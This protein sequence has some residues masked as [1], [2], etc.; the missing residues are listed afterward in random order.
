MRR[1]TK[2]AAVVLSGSLGMA[3]LAACGS[4]STASSS[5]PSAST[6]SVAGTLKVGMAYDVGGR[7]D[8]SFNDSAGRGLDKAKT[9]FG[10][11]TK[12]LQATPTD[13]DADRAS[14]LDQLA[15]N[16][17]NPIIAI[18]FAYSAALKT[19]AAKYPNIKFAIVDDASNTAANITNLVFTEEQSSYLVGVAAALKSK[20]NTVGFI[21][22]VDVPLIHKFQAGFQAG[23]AS[24]KPSDKVLVKYLTP[25]GNF[26][27]FSSPN[28]G[29]AAAQG[30]LSQ[31]ADVIYSAAGSS[32][33]GAIEAVH[34][35][36]GAW[37]IGVDSDQ[38]NL[39]GLAQ[40]KSSI[41]TS[42]LKN[43]DVAVYDYIQS[44]KSG[45]PLTGTQVF[46][47]DK[48]GVGYSTSGGFVDDIKA[49]LDKATADI[50]SKKVVVPTT[51]K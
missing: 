17:Y 26:A 2:I 36:P 42:A 50:T 21:G 47:L 46:S 3:S 10:I 43:V 32:G 38:Y 28:L 8:F 6:A 31:G 41:L 35:Q 33:N 23:V 19:E 16:G 37:A 30:M 1:V 11:Q 13:S 15:Q 25:A 45:T 29:K 5:S 48:N 34:A 14:R 20:T 18:G 4:N 51:V 40:Y 22:G 12:E 44:V 24:V 7:G 9:D 39:P 27:G 49:Q